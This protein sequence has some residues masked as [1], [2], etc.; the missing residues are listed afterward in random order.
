LN[1][2]RRVVVLGGLPETADVLKAVLEP[3]GWEVARLRGD[4]PATLEPPN[5][6]VLHSDDEPR[7][8]WVDVP[9]VI[10]G[11]AEFP[12]RTDSSDDRPFLAHPFQYAEL[13]QAVDRL[14]QRAA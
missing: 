1:D 11:T 6:V 5:L 14:L 12:D 4:R 10:I 13:I 9:T 8:P 7:N 3:R 2:D